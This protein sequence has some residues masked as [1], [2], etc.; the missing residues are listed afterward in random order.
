MLDRFKKTIDKSVATVSVKSNEFIEITKLKTQNTTT[1][2]EI[3]LLKTQLGAAFY[4]QWR[5]EAMETSALEELCE[6]INKK[7]LIILGNLDRIDALQRENDQILGS[8]PQGE[9]I[10]CTCG[11]ENRSTAKFCINCGKKLEV[12][13]DPEKNEAVE[14]KECTCGNKVR[15]TAK[16][17][18]K[19]GNKLAD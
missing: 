17:C 4:N 14:M 15:V 8:Q 5:T 10:M 16:F 6:A 1:E 12:E 9:S 7:E 18:S 11:K 2:K 13:G 19:C 3:D